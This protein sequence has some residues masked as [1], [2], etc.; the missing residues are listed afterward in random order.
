VTK[1]APDERFGEAQENGVQSSAK[2]RS[3]NFLREAGEGDVTMSRKPYKERTDLEKCQ[4][5]WTKLQ[6]LHSLEQWSAAI[7]RAAT[8]AEI[9]ANY[10]IRAEFTSQSELSNDFVDSLLKWANG[11]Q[12]KI[13][14]LLMPLT[15]GTRKAKIIGKL[16]SVSSEINKTRNAVV[17]RGE[18]RDE[19]EATDTIE[20]TRHFIEK[21]VHLYDPT[22]KLRDKTEPPTS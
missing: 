14:H 20:R 2:A 13:D 22:F 17:H 11:L 10:A 16:L 5:Q 8:A 7:V 12:G 6:G 15:R 9:A 21:L 4:S 3:I 19:D 1:E 18:F